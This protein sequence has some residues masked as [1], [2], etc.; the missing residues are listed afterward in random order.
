MFERYISRVQ[1]QAHYH[2]HTMIWVVLGAALFSVTLSACS[3][4]AESTEPP[5]EAVDAPAD[6]PN[7]GAQ[8]PAHRLTLTSAAFQDGEAIPPQFT[9]EGEDI[10]PPLRWEGDLESVDSFALI[11]EDPDAPGGTWTHW[12][13]YNLPPEL[14]SLEAVAGRSDLPA[15]A[16]SGQN[17]WGDQSY[18]GPCPP[19]GTHRYFF[20]LFA[21]GSDPGLDPGAT[22]EELRK[23]I[24]DK[25]LA[26]AELMGTFSR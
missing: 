8:E 17:D 15:G 1:N 11:M 4:P 24:T 9:C 2:R 5:F 23:A 19:S 3:T 21:L 14:R 22:S 20:Y 10:S 16:K 7:S 26:S 6:P 25:I 18:G 13:L 12:V